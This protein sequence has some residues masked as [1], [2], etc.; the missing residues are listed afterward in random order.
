MFGFWKPAQRLQVSNEESESLE[1]LR[2]FP[3]GRGAWERDLF[4]AYATPAACCPTS[5]KYVVA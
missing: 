5:E 4:P 2:Y 1:K 3:R